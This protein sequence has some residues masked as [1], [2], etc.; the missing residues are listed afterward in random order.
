MNN[1]TDRT[2]GGLARPRPPTAPAA[3]AAA[4]AGAVLLAACGSASYSSGSGPS[5]HEQ[6]IAAFTQCHPPG[7]G[8]RP[9]R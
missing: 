7:P 5:T 2:G 8:S 9:Q 6:K 3:L 4:L 1:K